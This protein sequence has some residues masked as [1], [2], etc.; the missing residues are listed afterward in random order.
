MTLPANRMMEVLFAAADYRSG[1]ALG[2]EFGMAPHVLRCALRQ[3]RELGFAIEARPGRGYRARPAADMPT[4]SAVLPDLHSRT[5]GSAYHFLPLTESTNALASELARQGAPHG[6]VVVTEAQLCGRGRLDRRWASPPGVNLYLSVILRPATAAA[7]A[8]QVALVA[9]LAVVRAMRRVC[10]GLH[11]RIKWPN[12]VFLAG[13]KVAGILS[14]LSVDAARVRHLVV[15]I[16]INVNLVTSTLPPGIAESATSIR[17][18]TGLPLA[19][20]VL[21]AALLE[22][23]ELT[24]ETWE[25][26]GLAE[27]RAAWP[28]LS[29]L[30]GRRVRLDSAKGPVLGTAAGL[31]ADGALLLRLDDGRLLPMRSGDAHVAAIPGMSSV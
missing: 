7:Q 17:E 16:G 3:L 5:L 13:R 9:A 11:P 21:L 30:D 8:P 18:A 23:L 26:S 15:G 22:E 1:I 12:D 14:E 27:V 28:E 19:R 10:P 24:V 4:A 29:V 31:A 20:P 2:R 6:T 25:R